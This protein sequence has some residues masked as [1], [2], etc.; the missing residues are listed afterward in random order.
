MQLDCEVTPGQT[1]RYQADVQR[2]DAMGAATL[3]TVSRRRADETDWHPIGTIELMFSH[4]DQAMTGADVPE[5]NFVFGDNLR[6]ILEMTPG[7]VS[8]EPQK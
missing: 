1:L 6:V 3:G 8:A 7:V 2:M 5:H 4:V